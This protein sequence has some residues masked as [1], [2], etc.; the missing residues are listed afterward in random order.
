MTGLDWTGHTPFSFAFS[1]VLPRT[2]PYSVVLHS[3]SSYNFS[4]RI[5]RKHVS[6]VIKNARLFVRYLATRC[7]TVHREHSSFIECSLNVYNESLP[8]NEYVLHNIKEIDVNAITVIVT[9]FNVCA[10]YTLCLFEIFSGWPIWMSLWS[11][12]SFKS[13]VWCL[14]ITK[15]CRWMVSTYAFYSR[16]SGLKFRSRSYEFFR[17]FP[18]F[19]QAN[20]DIVPQVRS[21]LLPFTDFQF[22]IH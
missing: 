7:S 15:H 18:Q 14:M 13:N 20:S 22:D 5:P 2:P 16:D 4:A 8:S 1:V 19:F 6:R 17:D 21:Q 10:L 12:I 9:Q 3:V 11:L